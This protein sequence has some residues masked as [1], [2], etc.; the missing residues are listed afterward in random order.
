[1]TIHVSKCALTMAIGLGVILTI[2]I[3]IGSSKVIWNHAG[4]ASDMLRNLQT[5]VYEVKTL[6]GCRDSILIARKRP[7]FKDLQKKRMQ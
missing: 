5:H 7:D 3:F 2:L 4:I 6:H 1:M